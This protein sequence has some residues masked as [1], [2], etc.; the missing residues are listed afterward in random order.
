MLA[1]GSQKVNIVAKVFGGAEVLATTQKQFMIGKRN[2]E[3]AKKILEDYRI[4]VVGASLGG[5]IGR[6]IIFHTHTG[7]VLMRFVGQNKK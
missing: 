5:T 7:E 4:P 2:I 3:I 1:L 6:K